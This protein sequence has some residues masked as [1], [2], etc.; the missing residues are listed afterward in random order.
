MPKPAYILLI[1]L[2]VGT[3]SIS[4]QAAETSGPLRVGAAR[5]DITP[6]KLPFTMSGSFRNREA[7]GIHDRLYAR[8]IVL[9]DGAR[10]LSI[11]LCDCLLLTRDVYDAAKRQAAKATGIPVENMMMAATHTHS[12]PVTVPLGS[13]QPDQDYLDFL[14]GQLA[15]SVVLASERLQPAQVGWVVGQLPGEVHN[16]R[17]FVT[18]ELM[19][20]DPF[21][22]VSDLVRTNPPRGVKGV[23][24]PAGP[25]DPDVS[26]LS[27]RSAHGHPLALLANYSLHYVGGIPT[28]HLSADYFGEF[29]R[30]IGKRLNA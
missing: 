21:G 9:D 16:R 23:L 22:H 14:Q 1:L 18:P 30:E 27:V 26:L 13:L 25:V 7:R 17:W 24:R 6:R 3:T 19:Q 2:M 15:A 5:I 10:R 29:S 28:G 20:P 4:A 8:T 12:G 11:T